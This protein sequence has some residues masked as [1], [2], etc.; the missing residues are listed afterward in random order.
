MQCKLD[1]I[2][3]VTLDVRRHYTL[4]GQ[5]REVKESETAIR[6]SSRHPADCLVMYA[7]L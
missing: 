6:S 5:P 3:K 2:C 4:L 7:I 1:Q